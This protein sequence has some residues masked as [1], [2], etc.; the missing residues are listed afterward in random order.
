MLLNTEFYG[1]DEKLKF[2]EKGIIERKTN[3]VEL[4]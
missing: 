4:S 1:F 3:V 2:N